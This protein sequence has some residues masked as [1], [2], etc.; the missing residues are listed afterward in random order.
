MKSKSFLKEKPTNVPLKYKT[1]YE[2]F[3]GRDITI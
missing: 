1:Q 3:N 2:A